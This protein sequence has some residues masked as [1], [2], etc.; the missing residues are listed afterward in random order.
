MSLFN[1]P[2]VAAPPSSYALLEAPKALASLGLS[3]PL[4]VAGYTKQ[5]VAG[6]KYRVKLLCPPQPGEAGEEARA[7]ASGEDQAAVGDAAGAAASGLGASGVASEHWHVTLITPLPHTGE[8]TFVAQVE[9]GKTA[10]DPLV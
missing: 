1:P 2:R 8:A 4:A 3:P 9:T 6:T 7:A 5:V 10:E